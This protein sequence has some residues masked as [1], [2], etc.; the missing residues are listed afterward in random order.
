MFMPS[1]LLYNVS[2]LKHSTLPADAA[3]GQF[4]VLSGPASNPPVPAARHGQAGTAGPADGGCATLC[5]NN[6]YF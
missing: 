4:L 6:I 5:I 3:E 1:F 2:L